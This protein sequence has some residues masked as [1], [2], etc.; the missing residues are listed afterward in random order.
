MLRNIATGM[1][2]FCI[3]STVAMRMQGTLER[4]MIPP[5]ICMILGILLMWLPPRIFYKVKA[6]KSLD[7]YL[8]KYRLFRTVFKATIGE[9]EYKEAEQ[10]LKPNKDIK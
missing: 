9:K 10:L 7:R 6:I 4:E 2:I 5:L 8:L 3:I 1:T